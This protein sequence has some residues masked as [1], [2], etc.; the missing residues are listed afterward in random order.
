MFLLR[1]AMEE[2]LQNGLIHRC[3]WDKENRWLQCGL[4]VALCAGVQMSLHFPNDALVIFVLSGHVLKPNDRHIVGSLQSWDNKG[5]YAT[6]QQKPGVNQ[7]CRTPLYAWCSNTGDA[8][9]QEHAYHYVLLFR[10]QKQKNDD[11][12]SHQGCMTMNVQNSH[13][14]FLTFYVHL[15]NTGM[16]GSY[17]NKN[18]TV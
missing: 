16:S 5:N 10:H 8:T 9:T 11:S 3:A 17:F 2:L 13:I 7:W 12:G 6:D 1:A 4:K 15:D 18:V 14:K